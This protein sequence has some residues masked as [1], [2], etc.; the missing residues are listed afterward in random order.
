[1]DDFYVL[2]RLFRTAHPGLSKKGGEGGGKGQGVERRRVTLTDVRQTFPI[3]L[4]SRKSTSLRLSLSRNR[5]SLFYEHISQRKWPK[6]SFELA[7]RTMHTPAR[8]SWKE[9]LCICINACR[10]DRFKRAP[11]NAA[12]IFLRRFVTRG[13]RCNLH[14]FANF[15]SRVP[16]CHPNRKCQ[17]SV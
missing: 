5:S 2:L 8:V 12:S 9:C 4:N 10:N 1:M 13:A 17:E 11:K 3:I 16:A 7:K 6:P 14:R 15:S